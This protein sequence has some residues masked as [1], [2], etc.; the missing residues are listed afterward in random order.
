VIRGWLSCRKNT[1]PL[2]QAN[3]P[4]PQSRLSPTDSSPASDSGPSAFSYACSC[5]SSAASGSP[6]ESLA[7]NGSN[8]AAVAGLLKVAPPSVETT[9]WIELSWWPRFVSN[10]R[11]A[12]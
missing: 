11:Y 2:W 10:C 9:Y 1:K 12:M 7:S 6:A 5:A 8:S 3:G 4:E